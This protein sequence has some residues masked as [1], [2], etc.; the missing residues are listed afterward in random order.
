MTQIVRLTSGKA[1]EDLNLEIHLPAFSTA[2]MTARQTKQVIV[3]LS[4]D[5]TCA[6]T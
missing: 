5:E 2:A 3:L 1:C 4:T 6:T